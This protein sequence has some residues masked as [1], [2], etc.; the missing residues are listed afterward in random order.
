MKNW[1]LP[2]RYLMGL[3]LLAALI[4]FIAYA[5]EALE[6]LVIAAF[7]AYLVNPA[8]VLLS[9]STRIPR[10]AAVNIVYFSAILFLV[11]IPASFAPLFFNEF[12]GVWDD[13]QTLLQQVQQN[14]IHPLT[15]GAIRLDLS[16][17]AR[18]LGQLQTALFA[19]LPEDAFTLLESTSR[20]TVWL[21][22]IVVCVYIFLS[23]W[24]LMRD[25]LFDL[26][27]QDYRAEVVQLYGQLRG[28]WSAYLRGQIMLMLVVG[29]VFT[30]AWAILGIPG[31]LVL[32]VIAGLFTLVPDIG[33]IMAVILAMAV[34]LL[35][36]SSWIPLPNH[37]V[38]LIVFAVYLV[39]INLKNMWLRPFIMGRSLHMNEG[40]IFVAILVATVLNG[41]MG[42]LLVVPVMA[43]ALV[44]V[45]YL[46]NRILGRKPY[47]SN[48]VKPSL[49]HKPPKR[50]RN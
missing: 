34:T 46:T 48:I 14:L 16:A 35:E 10:R 47:I 23:E 5:Q 37:L 20:G 12:Q 30:I 19:P 13:V 39:L 3:L 36:G 7:I 6:P 45:Q 22:V 4:A 21:L 29:V 15:F 32:G 49:R 38:M 18:N 43:S 33:P 26:A 50:N 17:I 27:P 40:F 44:V 31:A 41:I 11:A 1:G 8:V 25:W 2:F 24:H 28:V 42:A 9:Q